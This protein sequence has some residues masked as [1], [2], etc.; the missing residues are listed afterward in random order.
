MLH[1]TYTSGLF[2]YEQL[3]RFGSSLHSRTYSAP[4]KG[5]SPVYGH[6]PSG[7]LVVV[8]FVNV[9]FC[10]LIFLSPFNFLLP[11]CVVCLFVVAEGF[12]VP[13]IIVLCEEC[14]GAIGAVKSL[15]L[16]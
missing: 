9:S 11:V 10:S 8:S 5:T 1:F 4:V 6:D 12:H 13:F 16:G 15:C 3:G 7:C 2:Q 14:A